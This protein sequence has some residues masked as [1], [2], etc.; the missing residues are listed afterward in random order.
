MVRESSFDREGYL[1]GTVF[2]FIATFDP[3]TAT[4]TAYARS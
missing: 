3:H 2:T 4:A 1:P